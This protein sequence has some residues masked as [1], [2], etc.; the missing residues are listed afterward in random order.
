MSFQA[1]IF[2]M[3]GLLMDSEVV[4]LDVMHECGFLQGKDIP[5][6]L[7]R[8]TIGANAKAAG[9]MYHAFDPGIDTER[10]FRDFSAAMHALA[11]EGRI[12][13]KKGA[14]ELLFALSEK[15]IPCAVASS[16]GI[17]TIEVYLRSVGV[18][19]MF[20]ALVTANGLPSKPAPDVF[21]KAAR[22]LNAAPERCLVLEDS[23]NGIRAGRAAGMT[24]CMVPD[25]FPF[26]E[27]LR[28]YCDHVLPDLA[29]VIPLL[30]A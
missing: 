12:P 18:K 9:E 11:R 14:K 17:G 27:A 10:L 2:D 24:V 8:D 30:D 6:S 25:V 20:A 16:S 5:V 29:A 15:N 3:D 22:E 4:G 28:P 21:L 1:V 26:T 19:D 7:I 13:L 23:I